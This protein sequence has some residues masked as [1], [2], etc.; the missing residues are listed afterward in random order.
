MF[1]PTFIPFDSALPPGA[2]FQAT[3]HAEFNAIHGKGVDA[4]IVA[5]LQQMDAVSG[6]GA[7][8]FAAFSSATVSPEGGSGETPLEVQFPSLDQMPAT[9]LGLT[10]SASGPPPPPGYVPGDTPRYY[11]VTMNPAGAE[12]ATWREPMTVCIDY[13]GTGFMD[14]SRI[15]LFH[16]EPVGWVEVTAHVDVEA[17]RV[18]GNVT[19]LATFALFEPVNQ[20]PVA[21]AGPDR[22][23]AATSEDGADVVLSPG[24]TH[25]P[26]QEPLA[27]EW[28]DDGGGLLAE[29]AALARTLPLGAHEL[30]LTVR[31]PRG[32]EASDSVVVTVTATPAPFV[33][34]YQVGAWSTCASEDTWTCTSDGPSGCTRSGTQTRTVAPSSWTADPGQAATEPPSSQACTEVAAGYVS[35]YQVGSWGA[36]SG[37]ESWTCTSATAAGCSRPATQTRTVTAISWTADSAQ[38]QAGPASSQSCTET[39]Q[40]YVATYSVG[41]WSECSATCGGG[42]QARSVAPSSYRATAPN[43][44][45]PDSVQSCT[46]QSCTC[47]DMGW[48]PADQ[49]DQCDSECGSACTKKTWCGSN[50][51][52]PWPNY[53]WKC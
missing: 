28:R 3:W 1:G 32:G 12:P 26:D 27:Y 8:T 14:E 48:Y 34:E 17:K 18:C 47:D 51:C 46:G 41:D 52:E 35:A 40:G 24:G 2:P 53:C 37:T 5:L 25:D 16:Q 23:V 15:L 38:A 31:D 44:S 30:T 10:I 9:P 4:N 42:Y 36:C 19:T 43:A 39:T 11:T 21:H 20:L 29:T 7:S 50:Q 49:R 33:S 13:A 22:T 45:A 6:A